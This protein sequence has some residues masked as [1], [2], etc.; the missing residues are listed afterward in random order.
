MS[1]LW[2]E[3]LTP[4]DMDMRAVTSAVR[5]PVATGGRLTTLTEFAAALKT[6]H[7]WRMDI[8]LCHL[9]RG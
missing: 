4:R 5:I 7:R 6:G 2:Y 1:P 3:D 8:F 9:L